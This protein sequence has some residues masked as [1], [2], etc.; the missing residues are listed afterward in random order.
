MRLKLAKLC[1]KGAVQV[2]LKQKGHDINISYEKVIIEVDKI[3]LKG[4]RLQL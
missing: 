4:G 3:P 2:H 1:K